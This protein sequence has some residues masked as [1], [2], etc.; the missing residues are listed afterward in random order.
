MNRFKFLPVA[1]HVGRGVNLP[2]P[3]LLNA[4]KTVGTTLRRKEAEVAR[5]RRHANVD[6]AQ[7]MLLR[8]GIDDHWQRLPR[9]D[10][11]AINAVYLYTY[12]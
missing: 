3:L 12:I 11:E 1:D 9:S 6:P 8:V 10:Q 4:E 5:S 7:A 2:M